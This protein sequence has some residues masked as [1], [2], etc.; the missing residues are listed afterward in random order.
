M[1]PKTGGKGMPRKPDKAGASGKRRKIG[2]DWGGKNKKKSKVVGKAAEKAAEEAV[3][4]AVEDDVPPPPPETT[5]ALADLVAAPPAVDEN[6]AVIADVV[7][8]PDPVGVPLASVDAAPIAGVG[9]LDPQVA[10][11]V[12]SSISVVEGSL[13]SVDPSQAA[14]VSSSVEIRT[15]FSKKKSG[16]SL[17]VNP[18]P[19]TDG[20]SKSPD[21]G[22]SAGPLVPP[23]PGSH[24]PRIGGKSVGGKSLSGL[25]TLNIRQIP[26]SS[27]DDEEEDED[28]EDADANVPCSSTST[29]VATSTTEK[30][31]TT[32]QTKV[33][34]MPTEKTKV[35]KV[36]PMTTKGTTQP[37][38]SKRHG[39]KIAK[40]VLEGI[41]KN[42]IGR[43]AKRAGVTRVGGG[44]YDEMRFHAQQYL[45][46]VLT[47]T[48]Y[49]TDHRKAQTVTTGD[50]LQGFKCVGGGTFYN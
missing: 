30:T 49:H 19:L 34:P 12:G 18:G 4:K 29:K 36:A 48:L 17:I 23:V 11:D 35:A 46:E 24:R 20:V 28:E 42:D 37:G 45:D 44:V 26:S 33:V 32:E 5:A 14:A 7:P 50:V 22:A 15:R 13:G 3:E 10:V 43:I 9:G 38:G 27:S 21:L 16:P 47:K 39:K 2:D 25:T 31:S 40:P 1:G 41:T 8:A 6:G